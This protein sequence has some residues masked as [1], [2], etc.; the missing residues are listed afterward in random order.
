M[1][2]SCLIVFQEQFSGL[3][4]LVITPILIQQLHLV[5]EQVAAI[6][7]TRIE[8]FAAA[9]PDFMR[10]S[11]GIAGQSL[12]YPFIRFGPIYR[13]LWRARLFKYRLYRLL[14]ELNWLAFKGAHRIF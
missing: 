14:N 13:I 1:S 12:V 8:A 7:M 5:N 4:E 6:A 9:Y 10:N 3:I 11:S 2:K